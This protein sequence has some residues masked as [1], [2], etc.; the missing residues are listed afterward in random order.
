[1]SPCGELIRIISARSTDSV[2]TEAYYEHIRTNMDKADEI[3]DEIIKDD[4]VFKPVYKRLL[5]NMSRDLV[6]E[7]ARRHLGELEPGKAKKK[8]DHIQIIW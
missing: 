4:R 8:S 6:Q 1:M 5:D 3:P 7:M 2:E